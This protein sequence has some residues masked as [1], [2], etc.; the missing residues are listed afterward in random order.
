MEVGRRS[1]RTCGALIRRMSIENRL[2]QSLAHVR[3]ASNSEL[4]QAVTQ[5]SYSFNHLASVL[6]Q[7]FAHEINMISQHVQHARIGDRHP[8]MVCLFL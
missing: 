5:T 7:A 2:C 4:R 6:V 1:R 3:Y 8:E